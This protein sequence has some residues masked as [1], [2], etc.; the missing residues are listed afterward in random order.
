MKAWYVRVLGLLF[1]WCGFR[2]WL[3]SLMLGFL[4]FFFCYEV[5]M[6]LGA[7]GV[8]W[9]IGLV[10]MRLTLAFLGQAGSDCSEDGWARLCG[11][12]AAMVSA[13]RSE[14]IPV[15]LVHLCGDVCLLW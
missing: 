7:F 14:C 3:S 9:G 11:W 6:Y 13:F 2:G 1:G 15:G 12:L 5:Q 10:G 8:F 4:E